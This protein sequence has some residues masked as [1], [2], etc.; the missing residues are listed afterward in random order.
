[1]LLELP[2]GHIPS[3]FP[4]I[5]QELKLAGIIPIIAHPE[6]NRAFLK[7]PTLLSDYL[8]Q[9][10]LFQLTSQSF[11]GLFG[12][13]VQRWCF[14]FCKENGFHFIS[15]DAHGTCKRTFA[16][17]EGVAVIEKRFGKGA[18]NCL[19]ENASYILSNSNVIIDRC[20][21]RRIGIS[22]W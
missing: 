2:F 16:M 13:K 15:S 8:N 17:S 12:R 6:R 20:K 22:I 10:V 9:G 21:P 4:G 7:K 3:Q 11:T 1:M 19:T 14:R 5:L 18:V